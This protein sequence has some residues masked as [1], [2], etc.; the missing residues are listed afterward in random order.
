MS[1]AKRPL[2][3]V[4][5]VAALIACDDADE[6]EGGNHDAKVDGLRA[7]GK[8]DRQDDSGDARNHDSS[9]DTAE[10]A[11]PDCCPID[12]RVT[13]GCLTIGGTRPPNGV[14]PAVC[15]AV[16]VV[17]RRFRDQNGCAAV[18]LSPKSC[19]EPPDASS[20]ARADAGQD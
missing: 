9:W 12:E 3:I 20:D 4:L 18:E 2:A 15:D 19:L 8:L 13:C 7:D 6:D 17:V 10:V 1:R 16:P 5:L 14:C 11:S